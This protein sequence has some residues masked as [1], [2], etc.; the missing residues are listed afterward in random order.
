MPPVSYLVGAD[1]ANY[2]VP[3]ATAAQAQQASQLVN[4]HLKRPEG[5]VWAPD[6]AGNPAY[7]AGL[8]PQITYKAPGGIA[9][10]AAVTV[11]LT[12]G[13]VTLDLIGEALV[14]DRGNS[15]T[16][17]TAVVSGAD[18]VGKTITL[19]RVANAHSV[20]CPLDR[21]CTIFEERPLPAERSLARVARWPVVSLLSG[22]GRYAYGRRSS[23]AEGSVE[24]FNLLLATVSHF[25]GPPQWLP[26]DVGNASFNVTTGE[27]WVPSG[28]LLAYYSEVRLWY[29]AGWAQANVPADIKQACANII[30]T[31]TNLGGNLG[32]KMV[33]AGDT[34]IQ[35]GAATLFDDNTKDLL[36][37]Y[38]ARLFA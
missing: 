17:E 12:G 9:A 21:G 15:A 14:L 8:D 20:N 3:G 28:V 16:V 25:G 22:L 37:P 13:P 35:R 4:G 7:M 2:G 33:R 31:L 26:F 23:Q 18:P 19:G 6:A 38:M 32:A 11:P 27:V 36:G 24:E 29:V 5:L 34:A 30:Q 1:L 10:G